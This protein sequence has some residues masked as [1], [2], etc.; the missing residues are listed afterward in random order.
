MVWE[1]NFTFLWKLPHFSI[2]S[3]AKNYDRNNLGVVNT[4]LS[5]LQVKW[6]QTAMVVEE[7]CILIACVILCMET[8]SKFFHLILKLGWRCLEPHIF[9]PTQTQKLQH[10]SCEKKL[11]RKWSNT[12]SLVMCKSLPS[13][14][15]FVT[16]PVCCEKVPNHREGALIVNKWRGGEESWI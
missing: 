2:H 1:A 4:A 6:R 10:F 16:Y 7:Q 5:L 11:A 9:Q 3:L 15:Y 12:Y 8:D 13:N 14:L